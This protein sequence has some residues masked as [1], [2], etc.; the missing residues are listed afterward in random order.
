MSPDCVGPWDWSRSYL[1]PENVRSNIPLRG[2]VGS[3]GAYNVARGLLVE[4]CRATA[5]VPVALHYAE[6]ELIEGGISSTAWLI[7]FTATARLPDG[8]SIVVV[9]RNRQHPDDDR[10]DDWTIE[11]DGAVLRT[12]SRR[13]PPSPRFQGQLVAWHLSARRRR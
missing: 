10:D 4:I 8:T 2:S 3:P 13:Y 9:T 12:E 1:L 11:L 6:S 5:A 7:T